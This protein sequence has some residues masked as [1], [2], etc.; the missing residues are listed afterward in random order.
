MIQRIRLASQM[1]Q[2]VYTDLT[3]TQPA[4]VP[5]TL[6]NKSVAWQYR[7]ALRPAIAGWHNPYRPTSNV[8]IATDAWRYKVL[9]TAEI[10]AIAQAGLLA[11]QTLPGYHGPVYVPTRT[12]RI[13]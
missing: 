2:Q 5:G 1:T 13:D 11:K 3:P 8:L 7:E 4:L 12:A 10:Q 6:S 9:S